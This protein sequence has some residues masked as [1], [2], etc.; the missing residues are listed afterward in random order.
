MLAA[1][2]HQ[3]LIERYASTVQRTRRLLRS[4]GALIELVPGAPQCA[5]TLLW[6]AVRGVKQVS[7]NL[8]ALLCQSATRQLWLA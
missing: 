5:A 6:R 1:A 7:A 8:Q 3:R 2:G 4:G